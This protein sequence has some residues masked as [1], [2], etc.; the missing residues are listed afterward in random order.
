[1]GPTPA[2]GAAAATATTGATDATDAK[3]LAAR[4]DLYGRVVAQVEVGYASGDAN[5]DDTTEK[6]FVFDPNHKVGLLLF[7]EVMRWQTARAATAAQDPKLVN[8]QRPP[9]GVTL[10]PTNGGVFGAQYIYPTAIYRPR[11]WLDLKAGA[12]IA[13]TT[14]DYVDPYRLARDGAYVNYSGGDA[15]RHDLGLE[16]DGGFEARVPLGPGLRLQ[17]GAQGGVL[18]PG[19]AL[20]DATGAAMKTPWIAVGRLGLQY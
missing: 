16:L 5:P 20:A 1:P 17:L 6:R 2:A 8:A 18:F 7:D 19:G 10:L 15:K 12:V 11:P 9:P 3:A 13:Q 4:P 14:S